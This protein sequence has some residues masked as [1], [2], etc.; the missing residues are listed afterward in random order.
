MSCDFFS[1]E[2]DTAGCIDSCKFQINTLC[3]RFKCRL[4]KGFLI[5][6]LIAHIVI[7]AVL[8]VFSILG[9]RQ[10]HRFCLSIRRSKKPACHQFFTF[11]NHS[12]SEGLLS[13]RHVKLR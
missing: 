12:F 2:T 8:T 3:L 4:C 13:V 11:S 10:I 7:S 6:A 5:R 9:M 1:V